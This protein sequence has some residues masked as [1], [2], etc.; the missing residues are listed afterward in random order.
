MF[1]TNLFDFMFFDFLNHAYLY[2]FQCVTQAILS[3]MSV[4]PRKTL[5][6][7]ELRS[8]QLLSLLAHP[9]KLTNVAQTDTVTKT[10]NNNNNN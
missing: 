2:V 3:L 7:E 10:D 5:R 9:S 8:Q 6:A 1:I 4:Y